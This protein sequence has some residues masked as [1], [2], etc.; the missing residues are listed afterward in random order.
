MSDVKGS[1]K[2]EKFT[3]DPREQALSDLLRGLATPEAVPSGI[4]YTCTERL[5]ELSGLDGSPAARATTQRQFEALHGTIRSCSQ[6]KTEESSLEELTADLRRGGHVPI[7][8]AD[9]TFQYPRKRLW[10]RIA[11]HLADAGA[12]SFTIPTAEEALRSG[13]T[14]MASALLE[15]RSIDFAPLPEC[16]YG[17]TVS[18]VVPGNVYHG[19]RNTSIT[20]LRLAFEDGASYEV[21]CDEPVVHIFGGYGSHVAAL[22][23]GTSDGRT[24]TARFV[25]EIAEPGPRA[26]TKPDWEFVDPT[27]DPPVKGHAWV[28]KGFEGDRER[29]KI[30]KPVIISEGFPGNY[31]FNDFWAVLNKSNFGTQLRKDGRDLI[32]LGFADGTRRIEH[33]AKIYEQCIKRA[34]L[35]RG[36]SKQ[37]LICGGGSM[38]GLIARYALCSMET[39][40]GPDAHQ[41]A[42]YFSVDTPHYGANIPPS[43]Q[44][45][46][47]L[48]AKDRCAGEAGK[49]AGQMASP[50]AQQMLLLW[51]PPYDQWGSGKPVPIWSPERDAFMKSLRAVGWMPKGVR[52]VGVANGRGDAVGNGVPIEGS[53]DRRLALGWDL[54]DCQHAWMYTT[55]KGNARV[56]VVRN[57]TVN[58]NE[59]HWYGMGFALDGAPG[60]TRSTWRQTFD[61]LPYVGA[62][63]TRSN[64]F[65]LHCFVPTTSACGIGTLDFHMNI[66]ATRP[67]SD[68]HGYKVSSDNTE[69]VLI[70][71]ELADYLLGEIRKAGAAP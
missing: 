42:L 31:S 55:V 63:R 58:G 45:F 51:I 12:T 48:Y 52:C 71:S 47:Q 10:A 50:A 9:Y 3:G 14:F 16:H 20:S 11:Q 27:V 62:G 21:R 36:P 65:P 46:L 8:V 56:A 61:P 24:N 26:D 54:S 22:T 43:V 32:M 66:N 33:N 23:V 39:T 17:R 38:G 69:H 40:G 15:H 28:L 68:L 59:W 53:E 34:I 6:T 49:Y 2:L 19:N 30:E 57:T 41:A 5:D 13:S 35:E 29:S 4:L 64:K 1:F 7:A 67:S 44:A 18:F 60:G 37:K 70:T 25:I